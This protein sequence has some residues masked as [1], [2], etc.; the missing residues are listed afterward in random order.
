MK[1]HRALPLILEDCLFGRSPCHSAEAVAETNFVCCAD[2]VATFRCSIGLAALQRDQLGGREPDIRYVR[3]IKIF[4]GR[5]GH[6]IQICH[7]QIQ[8]SCVG[9]GEVVARSIAPATCRRPLSTNTL[10]PL[11]YA[12]ETVVLTDRRN[13]VGSMSSISFSLNISSS[14]SFKPFWAL[15]YAF[16]SV[17]GAA[18]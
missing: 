12:C 2:E 17:N 8:M 3:D 10:P 7:H 11:F 14:L 16:P 9:R 1:L 18:R 4:N 13:N 6:Q 15:A 5:S